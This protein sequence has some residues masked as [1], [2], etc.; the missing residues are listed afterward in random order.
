MIYT[1]L[2]FDR[3]NSGMVDI[4]VDS[5]LLAMPYKVS[6][7]SFNHA[8]DYIEDEAKMA[9]FT[10]YRKYVQDNWEF[11]EGGN[12]I[13]HTI[14]KDNSYRLMLSNL[15]NLWK[16]NFL[17]TCKNI[18]HLK[19]DILNIQPHEAHFSYEAVHIIAIEILAF[20]KFYSNNSITSN[21][22]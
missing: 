3:S 6:F 1:V 7:T 11:Y 5:G 8:I 14:K 19:E 20:A 18:Y 17:N 2:N 15:D 10:F 9:I 4:Q 13:I 12:G 21:P 16:R 22:V